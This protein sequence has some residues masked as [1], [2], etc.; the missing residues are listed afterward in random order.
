MIEKNN[1][2]VKYPLYLLSHDL[3]RS[4]RAAWYHSRFFTNKDRAT[5][6]LGVSVSDLTYQ[7]VHIGERINVV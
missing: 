7:T 1:M 5:T 4:F 2:T 6:H 3:I